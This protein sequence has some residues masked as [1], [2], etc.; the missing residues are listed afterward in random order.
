MAQSRKIPV[1]GSDRSLLGGS[2]PTGSPDPREKIQV[3]VLIRRP[4]ADEVGR[5]VE[6]NLAALPKDRQHMTREEFQKRFAASEEDIKRI[7]S[8]ATSNNLDVARVDRTQCKVVLSGTVADFSRAFDV[9]LAL[10]KHPAGTYRGR[11]GRIHVPDEISQIVRGVFGLDN[12]PQAK[13]HFR[14]FE[15]NKKAASPQATYLPTSLA[16]MYDYPKGLDGTGQTIGIIELGGGFKMSDLQ[17]YFSKLGLAMP[18]VEAVSV[19]GA[20]NSPT[21][22]ANGPDGEVMLDIEVAGAIA[23]K[24][25]IMVYFG[26]NTDIGFLDAIDAAVHDAKNK[27]SVISI[28]WGGTES[29]W[30]SQS[31]DAFNQA[32]KNASALGVTVSV[33]AGDDGS[34]DGVSDGLAHVDFPASSPYVLACGGTRINS[35]DGKVTGEVVWNELPFMGATG[36]GISDAFDLPPWQKGA[37]VPPSANPGGRVGRGLPDVSG[38]ADPVTG[39]DVLVDGTSTVIG[40]TSAVAPLYAGLVALLNQ[41]IGKPVGYLNPILYTKV[42]NSVFV[43]ITTGNNGAYKAGSGWDAC[44]GLG[45]ADG[46]K[47]YNA[48]KAG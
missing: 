45:R 30:T 44:S 28:S 3:T 5:R 42:P 6:Q 31:L 17:A 40:G 26:P 35:D 32:F 18:D 4:N 9:K 24:S 20:T 10:Y 22:S 23:P 48:L 36:G 38:D 12:R 43:D 47:L 37:K 46:Q 15:K 1:T 25:K 14:I 41:G 29:N 19:D 39:Y 33:A 2:T 11:T 7:E 34:S 8:F 13:P 16:S 21:G 27:P